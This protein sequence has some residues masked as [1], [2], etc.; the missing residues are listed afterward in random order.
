M[1]KEL[2]SK[3][4]DPPGRVLCTPPLAAAPVDILWR[5]PASFANTPTLSIITA[6]LNPSLDGVCIWILEQSYNCGRSRKWLR[7]EATFSASAKASPRTSE[8]HLHNYRDARSMS[9]IMAAV[10]LWSQHDAV[11]PS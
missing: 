6:V 7:I 5:D 1:R 10:S 11:H 9:A 2:L 8:Y 4:P 3:Q